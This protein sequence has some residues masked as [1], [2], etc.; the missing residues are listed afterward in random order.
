M[1]GHGHCLDVAVSSRLS[2][3]D[4]FEFNVF[5][6]F[7]SVHQVGLSFLCFLLG[8]FPSVGLFYPT[9]VFVLS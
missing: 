7:L 3:Y 8:S 1:T 5:M 9:L 6:R 4:G 2:M